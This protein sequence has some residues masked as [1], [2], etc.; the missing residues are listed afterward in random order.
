[1]SKEASTAGNNINNPNI[2]IQVSIESST[3]RGNIFL[4]S[5]K[6]TLLAFHCLQH[7][8]VDDDPVDTS[9]NLI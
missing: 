4:T 6:Q 9:C 7:N 5:R 2:D 1:M 3:G 8:S